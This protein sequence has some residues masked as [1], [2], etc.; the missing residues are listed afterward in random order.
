MMES[1]VVTLVSV[2]RQDDYIVLG[3]GDDTSEVY[4]MFHRSLPIGGE[5]DWGVYTE[6]C[7]EANSAY[8]AVKHCALER[9]RLTVE[10]ARP[11]GPEGQ[12]SGFELGLAVS[13][14]QYTELADGLERVFAVFGDSA[15][16]LHIA[17]GP[18]H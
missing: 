15:E 11:I 17:I 13:D 6:Y 5:E 4:L 3:L 2:H 14:R 12:I 8:D 7:D 16:V 9:S 10:L 18:S 1:F